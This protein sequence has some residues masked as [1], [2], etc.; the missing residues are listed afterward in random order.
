MAARV[1]DR[2]ANAAIHSSLWTACACSGG[3]RPWT[4]D[5]RQMSCGC[6]KNLEDLAEK[7]CA[8]HSV[9]SRNSSPLKTGSAPRETTGTP[10]GPGDWRRRRDLTPVVAM[11]LTSQASCWRLRSAAHSVPSNRWLS[12]RRPGTRR[13]SNRQHGGQRDGADGAVSAAAGGRAIGGRRGK[14]G[15]GPSISYMEGPQLIGGQ[16]SCRQPRSAGNLGCRKSFCQ[17]AAS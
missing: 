4:W 1:P 10:E 14:A 6:L 12:N 15:R 7:P 17:A 9:S 16:Q 11:R 8:G 13:P 3:N 5:K 2:M